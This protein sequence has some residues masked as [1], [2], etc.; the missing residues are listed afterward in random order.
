M[1]MPEGL[2]GL[3]VFL[4][5]IAEDCGV[6]VM[7]KIWQ[8]F[9]GN[10]LYIPKKYDANHALAQILTKEEFLLLINKFGGIKEDVAT[11]TIQDS[12]KAKIN[13]LVAK[14]K[15]TAEIARLLNCSERW[16]RNVKNDVPY[17]D[18]NQ[19]SIFDYIE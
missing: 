13:S 5:E 12:K 19:T 10:Q 15:G 9:A 7:W 3:P 16:V 11:T 2:Q 6:P 18:P 1:K 14:G 8:N 4:T 17:A